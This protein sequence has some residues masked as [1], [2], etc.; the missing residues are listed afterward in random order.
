MNYYSILAKKI[1][2]T[3][4]LVINGLIIILIVLSLFSLPIIKSADAAY[5]LNE[6]IKQV[7]TANNPTVYYLDHKLGMKKAYVNTEAFLSYGNKWNDIKIISENELKK[8]SDIDLIKISGN[9]RVYYIKDEKKYLIRNEQEFINY[10]FEWNKIITINITD[11]NSYA[12]DGFISAAGLEPK[13]YGGV[14]DKLNASLDAASPQGGYVAI[15]TKDNL[16]AVFNL[17]SE[18]KT[19]EIK[20]L[21]INYG[22]VFNHLAIARLHLKDENNIAID[23]Q[24][25]QGNQNSYVF[26]FDSRPFVIYPNSNRK[27]K[28]YADFANYENCL[29][30]T[31][32]F[33]INSADDIRA[34]AVVVGKFPIQSNIFKLINANNMLGSVKIEGGKVNSGDNAIVGSVDQLTG[35]ITVSELLNNEDIIIQE[36][37]L[38]NTGSASKYDIANFK[39]KDRSNHIVAQTARMNDSN[40]I[41]FKLNDYKIAKKSSYTFAVYCDIMDGEL[42][43]INLQIAGAKGK[44]ENYGFNLNNIIAN[45]DNVIKISRQKLGAVSKN[46]TKSKNIFTRQAGV[47]FGVFQI[48]NNNQ[49]IDLESLDFRMEKSLKAP[50][51][52]K[53]F[54]LVNYE[55]GEVYSAFNGKQFADGK[56]SANLNNLI[57]KPKS[58]LTVAL[59]ADIPDN[60][61]NNSSYKIILDTVNYRAENKLYY[62]DY[63]NIAGENLTVN[64]ANLSIFGNTEAKSYT[65]GQKDALIAS[66]IIE[67]GAGDDVVVKNIVVSKSD[68][69][70]LVA[71][72]NGFS[73]LKARINGIKSKNTIAKPYGSSAMFEFNYRLKAG[74][75]AKIKIYAD[76]DKNLNSNET[77]LSITDVTAENYKTALPASISGLGANS[78]QAAYSEISAEIIPLDKGEI[79]AG[80]K[81]N[82]AAG[83]KIKNNGAEDIKLN[84]INISTD[85]AGFSHSLGFSNLKIVE[86][87]SGKKVGSAGKPVANSNKINLNGYLVPAKGEKIFDLYVDTNDN[88][89]IEKINIYFHNLRASGKTSK[90]SFTAAGDAQS[91]AAVS[92]NNGAGDDNHSQEKK[93]NFKKPVNGKITYYFHD[94]KYPYKDQFEHSGID[95]DV[96]QGTDVKASEDGT[97]TEVVDGG[98]ESCSYI[99]IKHSD[100]IKTLYAHLSKISVKTGDIVNQGQVIGKSGGKPGTPGAGQRTNGPHL[101]FEVLLR[102]NPVDPMLYIK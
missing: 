79:K 9:A 23:P 47:I 29:N 33:S 17:K 88:I 31:A 45:V 37:T 99:V 95:I 93:L 55:T 39:L 68:N 50:D 58:D 2:K 92:E 43:T 38:R 98:M 100:A 91:D 32:Q 1:L 67:A 75:R 102:D 54:Y 6:N 41:V 70:G 5:G 87:W 25:T 20:S 71:Y 65:K 27:I 35:K 24:S 86:R 52:D 82:F 60:L 53:T 96:K 76:L 12:L 85:G 62:S 49:T 28:L 48:R 97:V 66:F 44:G 83:F 80:E 46:L 59:I 101:H 30:Q 61:Q 63:L 56:A 36:I 34:N 3:N 7:K 26:N 16:V 90:I 69:S 78:Y 84:S 72:D 8:W 4:I 15:N 40:Y 18:K 51:P 73:N 10:G 14:D 21:N 77:K 11:L 94:P 74:G 57:L 81:N 42:R 89:P 19:I 13:V 22:G 64:K